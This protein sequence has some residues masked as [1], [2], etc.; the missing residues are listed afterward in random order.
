MLNIVWYGL[1]TFRARKVEIV[2]DQ[3]TGIVMHNIVVEGDY[4]I[5]EVFSTG[6]K[7]LCYVRTTELVDTYYRFTRAIG[8]TFTPL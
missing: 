4:P 7:T 3:K 1:K 8:F 2:V 6:E 5:Y